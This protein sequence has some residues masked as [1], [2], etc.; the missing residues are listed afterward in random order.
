MLSD[1][2]CKDYEGK[3]IV[4][5]PNTHSIIVCGYDYYGDPVI[6]AINGERATPG[7]VR[8]INTIVSNTYGVKTDEVGI[9]GSMT[10]NTRQ[11]NDFIDSHSDHR[12]SKETH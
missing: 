10:V 8:D 5:L 4:T 6:Y 2:S 12:A 7:M 11:V 9:Y 1:V 3:L